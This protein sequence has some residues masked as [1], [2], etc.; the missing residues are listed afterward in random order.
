MDIDRQVH[1]LRSY[2]ALVAVFTLLGV[3]ASAWFASTREAIYEADLQFF[4][5]TTVS[6]VDATPSEIYQGGLFAESRTASYA[7]IVSSPP[8]AQAIA[9]DLTV[10]LS[11][12]DLESAISARAREGTVLIDVTVE[13]SSPSVAQSIADGVARHFPRFV[14][15]LESRPGTQ[16]S[17]VNV[18]V[19]SPPG[20]PTSPAF[21]LRPL[22]LVAGLAAGLALG[23]AVALAWGHASAR[24]R[25]S[26]RR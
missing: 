6:P 18:S 17:P 20:R 16:A 10:Q 12:Q 13:G 3:G 9:R 25:F 23:A 21:P 22:Y 8:V 15:Q 19:T 11:P 26:G 14:N 5:S 4:V 2:W 7:R 24:V 1:V